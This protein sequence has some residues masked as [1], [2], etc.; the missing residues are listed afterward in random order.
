MF[1]CK[2]SGTENLRRNDTS[3]LRIEFLH[4]NGLEHYETQSQDPSQ[5]A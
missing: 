1:R 2:A 5:T 3:S 4:A